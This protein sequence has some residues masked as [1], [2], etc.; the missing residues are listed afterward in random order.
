M[1][2]DKFGYHCEFPA[3][4]GLMAGGVRESGNWGFSAILREAGT[5]LP[6]GIFLDVEEVRHAEIANKIKAKFV[7]VY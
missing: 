1:H 2:E 5:D 4:F 6:Q 7:R 3:G